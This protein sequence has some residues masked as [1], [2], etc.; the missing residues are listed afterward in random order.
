[1]RCALR[2]LW[3][4]GFG[5]APVVDRYTYPMLVLLAE[6]GPMR[7]GEVARWFRLDK[8]TVSRHLGRL[9]TAELIEPVDDRAGVRSPL[10]VSR[11][12]RARLAEISR[13]R[14]EWMGTAVGGWSQ[15]DMGVLADL[16]SRLNDGLRAVREERRSGPGEGTREGR[17]EARSRTQ[18][19]SGSPPLR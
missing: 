18:G 10:R 2:G 14:Q 16:L 12:G 15:D 8:S 5:P 7:V 11:A 17:T 13:A 19:R 4:E 3:D 9:A 1:V 6:E